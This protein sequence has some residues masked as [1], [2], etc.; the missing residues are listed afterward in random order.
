MRTSEMFDILTKAHVETRHGGRDILRKSL[1]KYGNITQE[2]IVMFLSLCEEC[3]LKS[4]KIRKGIVVQPIV[5]KD[6][7]SR[8]QMDLIDMQSSSDGV[9]KFILVYQDH[10]T[11]FIDL[12]PLKS[13]KSEEVAEHLID[14]FCDKG[15]PHVLQTENGRGFCNQKIQ[16]VLQKLLDCKFVQ[17]KPRHS[18]SQ[19]SIERANRD[20]QDI[21]T[22][23]L[24]DNNT[25]EWTK[26]ELPLFS[27]NQSIKINQSINQSKSINQ[28][29]S[30]LLNQ[31]QSI[32]IN[33]FN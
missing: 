9:Y 7:N 8:A 20:I 6:F 29:L 22:C 15:A 14:I 24:K 31:Y 16:E 26:G 18:Q 2:I 12:K 21:L 28:N 25:S 17:G 11:K 5:S 23:W 33:Q 13:K 1:E 3:Q 32:N 27:Q 4:R 19:G 30:R 10:L